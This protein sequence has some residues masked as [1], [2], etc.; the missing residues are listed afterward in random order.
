V[1]G[2]FLA[3]RL[4]RVGPARRGVGR[5]ETGHAHAELSVL[6]PELPVRLGQALEPLGHTSGPEERRGGNKERSDGG[7]PVKG[8]QTSYLSER[9]A[10]VSTA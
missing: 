4:T 8:Q 10:T 2:G 6:V 3:R 9:L 1:R 7:Q 5:L